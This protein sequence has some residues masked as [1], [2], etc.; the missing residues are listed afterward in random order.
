MRSEAS[1]AALCG[2]SPVEA[3]SGRIIRH[4]VNQGGNRHANNALWRIAFTRQRC[5][6]RTQ[7]YV[8][9]RRT[10]G[11]T[12]REITRCL[13]RYIAREIYRLLTNPPPMP[14]GEQLRSC[15]TQ[16]GLTL[17]DIAHALNTQPTR[18]SQLERDLHH[19]TQLTQN[20]HHHLTK[21]PTKKTTNTGC[22]T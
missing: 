8:Q 10:E 17:T 7:Q 22:Q 19:N 13:K 14:S 18:I 16:A 15:R 12:D 2:V 4:R 6:S 9:R 21:N 11:K 5:D 1:F 3:S 20:Y